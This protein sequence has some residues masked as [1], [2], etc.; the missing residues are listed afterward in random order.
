MHS[1]LQTS[2][3]E[4][5][6][7]TWTLLKRLAGLSS[8]PWFFFGDFNEILHLNEKIGGNDRDVNMNSDF[9]DAI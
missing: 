6:K 8:S 7:H 3:D 9:R 2:I 4:Q 5:E 1:G